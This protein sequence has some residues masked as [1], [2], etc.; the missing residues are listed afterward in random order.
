MNID[1]PGIKIE[2]SRNAGTVRITYF[3]INS[4]D[5]KSAANY[6]L[7]LLGNGI[8]FYLAND[9]DDGATQFRFNNGK[10]E[11]LSGG[12]GRQGDWRS[13]S[14]EDMVKKILLFSQFNT[15]GHISRCGGIE[16]KL[17]K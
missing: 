17:K 4:A 8:E 3:S 13:L 1:H 6:L 7:D 10:Y 9:N 11:S 16:E 14:R 5:M 2:G 15:G 12:H